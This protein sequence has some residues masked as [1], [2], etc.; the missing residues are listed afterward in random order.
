MRSEPVQ[1]RDFPIGSH[2]F[3]VVQVL[4]HFIVKLVAAFFRLGGL[5]SAFH[6]RW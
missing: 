6:A 1:Q 5:T 4:H 2:L 3:V